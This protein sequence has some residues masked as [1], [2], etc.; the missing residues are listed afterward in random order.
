[1]PE[2]VLISNIVWDGLAAEDQALIREAAQASVAVQAALWDALS[3]ASR[4]AVVD[5]GSEII[6]V[7]TQEFQ[8]AMGPL[9][10]QYGAAY[11]DLLERILAVE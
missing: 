11:G 8:D 10:E 5:A 2:V 6:T 9:Y 7:D 3:D 4:T 1:M